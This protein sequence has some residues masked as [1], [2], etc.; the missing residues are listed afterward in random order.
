MRGG[1]REKG[2]ERSYGWGVQELR[3]HQYSWRP[4]LR[5]DPTGVEELI[6]LPSPSSWWL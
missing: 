4:G 3:M 1:L 5:P 2:K 6:A